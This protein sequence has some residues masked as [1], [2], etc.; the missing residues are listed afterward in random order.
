MQTEPSQ[1]KIAAAGLKWYNQAQYT[2][3]LAMNTAG[4]KGLRKHV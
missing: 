1:W 4:R 3:D 2:G